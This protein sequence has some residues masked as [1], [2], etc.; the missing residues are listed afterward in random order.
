MGPE[1]LNLFEEHTMKRSFVICLVLA[2]AAGSAAAQT[3]KY[4]VTVQADPKTDFTKLKSYVWDA[5]GWQAYDKTTHEV[6]VAAVDRELAKQGLEKKASGP[7]DVLVTYATNRR[8]DVDLKSKATKEEMGRREYSVGT[9]VV[10]M[11]EPGTRRELFR[12]RGDQPIE[13]TPDKVKE[14]VDATVAEMFAK[15]PARRDK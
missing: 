11:L 5:A 4:G 9:L 12:A 3:Q 6:I 15:Y 2:L 7:A 10:L 1:T 13:V 8:T 14:V